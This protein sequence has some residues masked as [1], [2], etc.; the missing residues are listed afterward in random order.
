VIERE[1]PGWVHTDGEPRAET[2]RLEVSIKP[3]SLR[4]MVPLSS[5]P[6]AQRAT[7]A[8][9]ATAAQSAT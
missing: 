9:A 2:Q 1:K 4:I 5:L 3:R 6:A 7:T 8:G